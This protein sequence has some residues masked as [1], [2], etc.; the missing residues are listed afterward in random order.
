[1]DSRLLKVEEE[2]ESRA[3]QKAREEEE[4]VPDVINNFFNIIF[5]I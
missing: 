2:E 4:D 5:L 1:M 3:N